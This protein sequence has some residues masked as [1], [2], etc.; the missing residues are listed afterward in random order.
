MCMELC[1]HGDLASLIKAGDGIEKEKLLK[2][3]FVQ[4][5]HGVIALHTRAGF[6]HMNLSCDKVLVGD[7]LTMK[8]CDMSSAVEISKETSLIEDKLVHNESKQAKLV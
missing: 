4:I 3:M 6:A 7:D 5:C 1:S 8:V 2:S